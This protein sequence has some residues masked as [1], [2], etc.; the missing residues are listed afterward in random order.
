M[1]PQ[2][3]EIATVI[4]LLKESKI[5]LAQKKR[6]IHTKDGKEL[7]KSKA[8]WNGYGG[9]REDEDASIRDTAIRE[10]YDECGV[11]ADLHNL[12]PAGRLR[13][14][15]PDNDSETPNMDVYFFFLATWEGEPIETDEMDKP[16]FFTMDNI[17]YHEMLPADKIFLPMMLANKKVVADVFFGKKDENG[18]PLFVIRDEELLV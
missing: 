10:L 2:A 5:C 4:Y 17:P 7:D 16:I 12:I 6:H 11:K 1:T 8:T 14:F 9:K 15:W 3:T 18:L 13:F